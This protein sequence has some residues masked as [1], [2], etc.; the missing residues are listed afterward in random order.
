MNPNLD[1]KKALLTEFAS[2]LSAYPVKY[3]NSSFTTP[4]DATWINLNILNG[5][6]F[7]ITLAGTDRANGIVQVDVMMPKNKGENNAY[8]VADLLTSNLPKN[9]TALT[10]GSTDVFIRT[11]SAP[12]V[13]SDPNWHK[14]I[15]DVS[16]YAF[17]PR[18]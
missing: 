4:N 7:E 12:K 5:G 10:F 8:I 9:N 11:I 3:P 16:F 13:G 15:I 6:T 17:I 2:I 1:I 18:V 14:M